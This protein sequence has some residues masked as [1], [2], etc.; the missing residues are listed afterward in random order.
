VKEKPYDSYLKKVGGNLRKIRKEKGYS[1]ENLANETEMEY[2]QLGRIERGEINTSIISLLRLC[3][4]LKVELKD[5]FEVNPIAQGKT[6]STTA[7]IQ[8]N[9]VL[10]KNMDE[11]QRVRSLKK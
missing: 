10:Q 6:N 9:P 3:E 7:E 1:M 2:R 4:T 5:L 11:K 8:Y